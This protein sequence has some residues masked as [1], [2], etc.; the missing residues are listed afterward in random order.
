ML[1]GTVYQVSYRGS[2]NRL[3]TCMAKHGLTL[4]STQLRLTYQSGTMTIDQPAVNLVNLGQLPLED[5]H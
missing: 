2:D 5:P 3:L 1:P 4:G